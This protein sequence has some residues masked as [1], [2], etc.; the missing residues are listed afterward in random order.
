M[1]VGTGAAAVEDA[2]RLTRHAAHCGFAGALVLPPFYYKNVPEDGI[3]RFIEIIVEATKSSA[4]PLYLY[5]FPAMSGVPY[6][7]PLVKRLIGEFG[8]RLA[9]LKDSSGDNVYARAVAGISEDFAVFPGTEAKLAEARTGLFA[10]CISATAN[11]TSAF[12]AQALHHGDDG[13]LAV[14]IRIRKL[15]ESKPFVPG[16]K[17][18]LSR[19]HKAPRLA[20]VLP[21]FVSLTEAEIELLYRAYEGAGSTVVV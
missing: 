11:V 18:L 10:G 13:A 8:E 9:G 17:A 20:D 2:V 5:H 7:L 1:M 12:C 16:V 6:T 21:P 14:A 4:M 3:L 15:L 19:I